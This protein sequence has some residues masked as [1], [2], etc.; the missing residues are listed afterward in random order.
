MHF[1][2]LGVSWVEKHWNRI[3]KCL[4]RL[5]TQALVSLEGFPMY[6]A[7][8]FTSWL[9]RNLRCP[10]FW[11]TSAGG[12]LSLRSSSKQYAET[13]A[14]EAKARYMQKISIIGNIYPLSIGGK[15]CFPGVVL[16]LLSTTWGWF[17]DD[18]VWQLKLF[19]WMVS[20]QVLEVK[21][22]SKRKLVLSRRF[23]N[24]RV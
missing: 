14:P 9:W 5:R 3:A 13:L 11:C 7:F 15:C 22:H 4:G 23:Y 2:Y 21:V 8:P 20:H 10:P 17:W 18:R 6:R 24:P 16:V 1:S 12:R 19:Y